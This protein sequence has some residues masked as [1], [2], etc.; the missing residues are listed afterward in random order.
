[1]MQ[2]KRGASESKGE[3]SRN[4]SEWMELRN[5]LLELRERLD[6]VEFFV[7]ALSLFVILPSAAYLFFRFLTFVFGI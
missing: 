5:E 1:M 7:G 4:A 2:P 3:R 6:R